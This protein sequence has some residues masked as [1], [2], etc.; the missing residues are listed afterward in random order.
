MLNVFVKLWSKRSNVRISKQMTIGRNNEN[1]VHKHGRKAL[2]KNK[3]YL[4]RT[5][6]TFTHLVVLR[7]SILQLSMYHISFLWMESAR[8][9]GA[10]KY[11]RIMKKKTNIL[12]QMILSAEFEPLSTTSSMKYFCK[13]HLSRHQENFACIGI[14]FNKNKVP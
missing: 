8:E 3:Y 13:C 14:I 4:F 1:M 9:D 5:N 7:R 10:S 6:T 11:G 2:E 12:V